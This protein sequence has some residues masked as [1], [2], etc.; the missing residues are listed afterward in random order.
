MS[1]GT[2]DYKQHHI[3]DIIEEI[4]ERM[5]EPYPENVKFILSEGLH[6]LKRAYIFARRIDWFLAGGGVENQ[7]EIS[8]RKTK[9]NWYG[10]CGENHPSPTG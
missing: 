10:F 2:F 9:R 3:R 8:K 5:T 1:G 6:A 4:E 7:N